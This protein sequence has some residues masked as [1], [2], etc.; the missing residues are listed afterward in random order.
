LNKQNK[1]II[2]Y[3]PKCGE[4]SFTANC[5]K[6]F[7]CNKCGFTLFL[8][9]ASAVVAVIFN[10]KNELLVTIRKNNPAAGTYDLP[11]GF[12][13]NNETLELA[14]TREVKEE[15]NLKISSLKYWKS[16]SNQYVYKDILYYTTDSA[17]Y[18]KIENFDNINPAD[19]VADYKFI[20]I[21]NLDINNFGFSSIK[22]LIQNLQNENL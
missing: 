6:S 12:V 7:V 14:V 17:F 20:S 3:C 21:E 1:E 5:S 4:M 22:N 15:L 9:S 2:K 13:D 8:N 11:G 19:D 10:K 18:C 16:F